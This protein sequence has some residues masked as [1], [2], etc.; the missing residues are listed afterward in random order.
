M[1]E[2]ELITNSESV[3]HAS[4]VPGSAS[5][6]IAP[7]RSMILGHYACHETIP[8]GRGDRTTC[9]R[10][11]SFRLTTLLINVVATPL[12]GVT[13]GFERRAPERR[14]A[15]WLQGV[16]IYETAFDHSVIPSSLDIRH[17]SFCRDMYA[18]DDGRIRSKL[19]CLS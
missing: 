9:L 2:A 4:K 16:R 18:T 6:P 3:V 11:P 13:P 5:L 17:S 19:Q 12:W 7:N 10:S 15:P 8:C 14:T 1:T